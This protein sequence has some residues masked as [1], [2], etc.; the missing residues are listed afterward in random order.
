MHTKNTHKLIK[1]ALSV[2]L[3]LCLLLSGTAITYAIGAETVLSVSSADTDSADSFNYATA[4]EAESALLGV[5]RGEHVTVI[6]NADSRLYE[7]STDLII[8]NQTVGWTSERM[9]ISSVNGDSVYPYRSLYGGLCL[10]LRYPHSAESSARR[11]FAEFE[12]SDEYVIPEGPIS[13]NPDGIDFHSVNT[14]SFAVNLCSGKSETMFVE[15]YVSEYLVFT[16]RFTVSGDGW[17]AVYADISGVHSSIYAPAA[18]SR[19]VIGVE[20]AGEDGSGEL[21]LD[22]LAF[23]REN[24]SQRYLALS[25]NISAGASTLDGL[26][27]YTLANTAMDISFEDLRSESFADCSSLSVYIMHTAAPLTA[28]TCSYMT[29]GSYGSPVSPYEPLTF[30]PVGGNITV[31]TF[32]LP[33]KAPQSLRLNTE[34]DDNGDISLLA[35]IPGS[36]PCSDAMLAGSCDSCKYNSGTGEITISGT[37]SQ[38]VAAKYGGSKIYIYA[39]DSWQ[40]SD[41]ATLTPL[42][43][44][45]SVAVGETFSVKLRTDGYMTKKFTAV[46]RTGGGMLTVFRDRSISPGASKERQAVPNAPLKG[47][48]GDPTDAA[49]LGSGCATLELDIS[50]LLSSEPTA[51]KLTIGDEDYYF[52]SDRLSELDREIKAYDGMGSSLLLRL[53]ISSAS[54]GE[55]AMLCTAAGSGSYLMPDTRT[56]STASAYTAIIRLLSE[57]YGGKSALSGFVVGADADTDAPEE[58]TKTEMLPEYAARCAELLRLTY[59]ASD[60]TIPV[61]LPLASRL[62]GGLSADANG[63]Y[64]AALLLASIAAETKQRG[65]LPWSIF[66]TVPADASE[67]ETANSDLMS[68]EDIPS[69]CDILL[70]PSLEYSDTPRRIAV[71][72]ISGD[73]GRN[74]DKLAAGLAHMYLSLV[75]SRTPLVSEFICASELITRVPSDVLTYMDTSSAADILDSY[76]EIFRSGE[77]WDT[78][79]GVDALSL[80]TKCAVSVKSTAE[81]PTYLGSAELFSLS[82]TTADGWRAGIGCV[83]LSV[84]DILGHKNALVAKLEDMTEP[85]RRCIR[86][87]FEYTRDLSPFDYLSFDAFVSQLPEEVTEVELDILLYSGSSYIS[88]VC[89]LTPGEWNKINLPLA[90]YPALKTTDRMVIML[91]GENGEYIGSP[92]MMISSPTGLSTRYE[93][94]YLGNYLAAERTANV[95][96]PLRSLPLIYIM[97]SALVLVLCLILLIFRAGRR[98]NRMTAETPGSRYPKDPP[99]K[100]YPKD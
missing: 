87:T 56:E 55:V 9:E 72:A 98:R 27:R 65:E 43:P 93:D 32:P 40:S 92:T 95:K 13:G 59:T 61:Y 44:A 36:L 86:S 73:A 67:G 51:N 19:V 97:P 12:S 82:G 1:S 20:N 77:S 71:Y 26:H 68:G 74:T 37:L 28:I 49:M 21:L 2:L 80:I 10:S 66:L 53:R 84:S 17:N 60:C 70:S 69:L 6:S 16:E 57:R 24:A 38:D 46:I 64:P 29:D 14:L 18:I 42:S 39:L 79:F 75:G 90:D 30:A 88:S 83:S 23:S 58:Y 81:A 50:T 96:A 76:A 15:V 4:R 91:R 54:G 41:S 100:R 5:S 48:S 62:C 22:G 47:I 3:A 78:L 35:V 63:N 31:Y 34:G 99:R 89:S 94:G 7:A 45:A 25:D 11:E 85:S 33:E 8:D 52:R